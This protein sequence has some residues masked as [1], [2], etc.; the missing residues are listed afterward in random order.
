MS[1]EGDQGYM[2]DGIAEELL[3]LLAQV[4]DLKVI[5]RTSSF[6][7]KGKEA[8]IT[9]IAQKLN[10]AHVL[11]GTVRKSGNKI[12]ITARLIRTADSTHLWSENYDRPLDDIFAVQDEI[13]GAIAGGELSHRK[14]GTENLEAYQLYLR[15]RSASYLTTRSSLDAAVDYSEQALERDQGYGLAWSQLAWIFIQKTQNGWLDAREGYERV[16]QLAQHALQL[17]PDLAEAHAALVYVHRNAD[18]DWAAAET[19]GQRALAIDP[20]NPDALNMAGSLSYTLG[21]WD[22]AE[23]QLRAAL[24][25]DPLNTF[26]L[27]DLATT[28]YL[29]GRFAEAEG[30]YR[31]V[32]EQAPN[33]A[34]APSWLGKTLLAQG[35]PEEALAMVQQE[36]DEGDRLAYLPIVLQAVGRK[37][38]ADDALQ[39]QIAQW[40]DTCA[41]C[42]ARTYAHRGDRDRALDWLER[43]YEQKDTSLVLLVGEP[44]LKN[45]DD[46]PR[47]KAFLRKMNL[48]E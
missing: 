19:E 15:S 6:A 31:K 23:R 5:A 29:A 3:N 41:V 1:A 30:M 20:T 7:F 37:A 22:D 38:E 14:G 39:A 45:L 2:S 4:P 13:A 34:F 25:R 27:S 32:L 46:D 24:V 21:R 36:V 18:W 10:V 11:E 26:V 40:A 16:R 43:G 47:Y 35:R 17:S 8:D 48:P 44:L 42:V 33:S 12:R 28:Y 9:E